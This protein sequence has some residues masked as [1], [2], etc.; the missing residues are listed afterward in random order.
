MPW[1]LVLMSAQGTKP[2]LLL[3]LFVSNLFYYYFIMGENLR[4][5]YLLLLGGISF[6]FTR[7]HNHPWEVSF[8]LKK[9]KENVFNGLLC[10]MRPR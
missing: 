8:V 7:E 1:M 10:V 2:A 5:Q 6:F 9:L 3:L 4:R